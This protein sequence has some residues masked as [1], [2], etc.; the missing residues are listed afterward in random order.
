MMEPRLFR[1][2]INSAH[3]QKRSLER[4]RFTNHSNPKRKSVY[5]NNN[6]ENTFWFYEIF[7]SK[8]S[9]LYKSEK[10][11]TRSSVAG[12]GG[13]LSTGF[14][15][16]RSYTRFENIHRPSR[17]RHHP[18]QQTVLYQNPLK[19]TLGASYNPGG[20]WKNPEF[21]LPSFISP[22][23]FLLCWGKYI[24]EKFYSA[25]TSQSFWRS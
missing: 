12:V 22:Q 2:L 13:W 8:F 21:L 11:H 4:K 23:Q 6:A 3:R 1:R 9:N 16:M 14:T 7:N 10:K 18:R 17:P 20:G 25:M 15:G 24:M 19:C 5:E